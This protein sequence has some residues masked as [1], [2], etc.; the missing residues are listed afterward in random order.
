L[1]ASSASVSGRFGADRAIIGQNTDLDSGNYVFINANVSDTFASVRGP[2]RTNGIL[3]LGANADSSS[4]II[5]D[6]SGTTIPSLVI[7]NPIHAT[8]TSPY[9]T[10]F[11]WTF[12]YGDN[13]YATGL[14]TPLSP[15]GLWYCGVKAVT[16]ET[17]PNPGVVFGYISTTYNHSLLR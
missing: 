17:P 12:P 11:S 3:R 1:D 7:N 2:N 4:N 15:A 10:T 5:L 14:V 16:N 13:Q 9:I 6:N 8:Y